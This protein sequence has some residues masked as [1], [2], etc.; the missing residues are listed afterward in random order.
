MCL[1]LSPT[2]PAPRSCC[3]YAIL[4][5]KVRIIFICVAA[6]V[7]LGGVIAITVKGTDQDI[8]KEQ[9]RER[10]IA[11]EKAKR[12]ARRVERIRELAEKQVIL[13][14]LLIVI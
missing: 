12:V 13:V 11:E 8:V 14:T 10:Q 6:V 1:C 2:T 9:E 5:Q 3:A 4:L 7:V